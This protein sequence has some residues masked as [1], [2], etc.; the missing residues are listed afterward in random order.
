LQERTLCATAELPIAPVPAQGDATVDSAVAHKVR[1][2]RT[3]Q[4]GG[5]R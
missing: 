1:S 5:N 3:P 4:R 2:C